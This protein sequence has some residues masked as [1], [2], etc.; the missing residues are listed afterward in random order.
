M[1]HNKANAYIAPSASG[2]P[3]VITI[4]VTYGTDSLVI[5]SLWEVNV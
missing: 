1:S 4:A 3:T 5:G 2:W